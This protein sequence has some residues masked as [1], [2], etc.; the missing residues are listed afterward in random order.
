MIELKT[1]FI[2]ASSIAAFSS[3]FIALRSYKLAKKAYNLNE[4]T[5]QLNKDIAENEYI[6]TNSK[7]YI[8]IYNEELK[9]IKKVTNR[10]SHLL[11][12]TNSNLGHT[13]ENYQNSYNKEN[14]INKHLRHIYDETHELIAKSFDDELSYQTPENIY[15]RLAGFKNIN[16]SI[17]LER[18][19]TGNEYKSKQIITNIA[20][21]TNSIN[22]PDQ[23]K[24]YKDFTDAMKEIVEFLVSIKENI[25]SSMK[26]LEDGLS[27]NQIENFNLQENY[28]LYKLYKQLLIFSKLINQSKIT[29]IEDNPYLPISTIIYYGSNMHILNEILLRVSFRYW[30]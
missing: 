29:A 20:I 24:L 11:I 4:N 26:K 28:K 1:L 8:K 19:I 27:D 30:K 16:I 25:E 21:L 2:G 10:L 15:S 12:S 22:N 17:D 18:N 6:D 14:G 7:P 13:F 9:N 3:L 5:Y 23:E